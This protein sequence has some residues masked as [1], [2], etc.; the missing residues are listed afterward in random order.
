MA[1]FPTK[2]FLHI[3]HQKYSHQKTALNFLVKKYS[4]EFGIF[5]YFFFFAVLNSFGIFLND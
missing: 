5:I 4:R 3:A 1:E 2:E